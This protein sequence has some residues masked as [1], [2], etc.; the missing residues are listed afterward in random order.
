[1]RANGCE[2]ADAIKWKKRTRCHSNGCGSHLGCERGPSVAAMLLAS[3]RHSPAAA[4]IVKFCDVTE[5]SEPELPQSRQ[6]LFVLVRRLLPGHS[7]A[8]ATF[9]AAGKRVR[10]RCARTP[11]SSGMWMDGNRDSGS[12]SAAAVSRF[13][14][15]AN[16]SNFR[17]A[18]VDPTTQNAH[19]VG[20]KFE[21]GP[22]FLNVLKAKHAPFCKRQ[23]MKEK[24][25]KQHLKANYL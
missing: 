15:N 12:G 6:M 22:H 4:A 9:A 2:S 16:H 19:A 25:L 13:L 18:S 20:S 21:S 24:P 8:A 7:A 14:T 3:H 1:M 10:L 11:T 23:I 17:R 5:I